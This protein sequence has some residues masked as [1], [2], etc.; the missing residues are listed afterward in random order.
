MDRRGFI[1][2][3]SGLR[4]SATIVGCPRPAGSDDGATATESVVRDVPRD[5][6]HTVGDALTETSS[7]NIR[8]ST[9]TIQRA[10]QKVLLKAGRPLE[11]DDRE[12]DAVGAAVRLSD[13]N[14]A[15]DARFDSAREEETRESLA[16]GS[17]W[18]WAATS[19]DEP[20]PNVDHDSVTARG[21]NE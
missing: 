12:D 2:P 8:S 10:G 3:A 7:P 4:V 13:E 14:A 6:E 19:R 5:G 1:K 20:L 18:Q 21:I 16:S 17:S 9:I 15:Q 11:R